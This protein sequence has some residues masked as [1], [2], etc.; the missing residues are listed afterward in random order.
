MCR[1]CG[2]DNPDA[3]SERSTEGYY[4][5]RRPGHKGPHVA[6]GSSHLIVMWDETGVRG[7]NGKWYPKKA[8]EG[9]N[10]NSQP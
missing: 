10:A 3:C 9:H 7:R 4:C 5:T 1:F 8:K 6:C 2:H